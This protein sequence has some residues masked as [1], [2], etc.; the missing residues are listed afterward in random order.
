MNLF[1][2][3]TSAV[4]AGAAV[5][6]LAGGG[7]V[8]IADQMIGSQDV[9][10]GSLGMRDFNDHTKDKINAQAA[11][12]EATVGERGPAGPQGEQGE[13]GEKGEPGAP[14]ANG[15]NGVSGY[16]VRTWNY[17]KGEDSDM[18]ANYSGVGGGAI[19]TVACSAGK[20]ALSGGYWFKG[21]ANGFNSDAIRNG[22]AVVASFPGRMD[23]TTN[24]VKPND[25]SGWI[26]QVND[27]VAAA[28]MTL[29]VVCAD[30]N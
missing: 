25:Y 12:G 9:R 19:A 8:A 7:S 4:V 16:E 30:M 14:G 24:T 26:V 21:G 1:K 15:K 6:A 27:K 29:Y 28:D 10:N 17:T 3:R 20:A 13:K 2:S 23:W 11:T 18:G 22:S 5:L